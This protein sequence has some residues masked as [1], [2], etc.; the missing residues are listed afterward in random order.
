MGPGFMVSRCGRRFK[1]GYMKIGLINYGIGNIGSVY[2]AFRFYKYQINLINSA[3]DMDNIDIIVLAGVGNFLSAATRLKEVHFWD[4]LNEDV[5]VKKKP[6]LGICLGMH[7]FGT[8]SYEGGENNGFDWIS[9]KVLKI[10]NK[11][12]R[13]PHMGWN[14]VACSDKGLIKDMKNP[15]FYFMHSYHFVPDDKEVIIAT[16][17]YGN[18]EIVSAVK[19]DNIVGVQFHPEKSQGDGLRFIKRFVEASLAG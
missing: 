10:E 6:T 9:G 1:G 15:Y 11:K 17:N 8:V 19:K 16:T 14:Q 7:L 5:L 4:K 2:S 18:V 12:L 13:V 3:E